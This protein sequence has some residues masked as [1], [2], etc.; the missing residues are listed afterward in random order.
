MIPHSKFNMNSHFVIISHRA[1][2][3]K[4]TKSKIGVGSLVLAKVSFGELKLNITAR[5]LCVCV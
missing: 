2:K 1:K 5:V 4:W 3:K